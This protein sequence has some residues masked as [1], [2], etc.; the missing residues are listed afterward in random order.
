MAIRSSSYA[1]VLATAIATSSA[2]SAAAQNQ[3][4]SVLARVDGIEILQS[5]LALAEADIGQSLPPSTPEARRDALISYLIDV[6]IL[7][8]AAEGKKLANAP[9]FAVQLA[10]ARK[11]VLMEAL[12]N[13][14]SKSAVSEAAKHKLYDESVNKLTPEK[15][16]HARHILVE[17]EAKA[18]EVLAKLKA[19]G[20]F[21]VLAKET[22]KDPGASD[23]GDLGY[24]SKDQM[25]PEFAEVAF[26]LEKGK[27]SDPVKTQFGWHII[28]VE[29]TRTRPVPTYD[30]VKDQIEVFIVRKAQA[31]LVLKL[32]EGAKIERLTPQAATP[33]QPAPP[34]GNQKKN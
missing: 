29:D 4:D 13:E 27:L 33:A 6:T 19:G 28:K 7:S 16:V 23:G 8:K 3:A 25:V 10:H 34:A 12:L 17:S 18:K 14:E 31:E 32:R 21:V 20:D 9:G 11:K 22:S 1:L 26:K 5:A 15:E 24:F 30:Q 2:L